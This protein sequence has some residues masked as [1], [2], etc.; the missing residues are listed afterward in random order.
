[1]GSEIQPVIVAACVVSAICAVISALACIWIWRNVREQIQDGDN[2]VKNHS[3]RS[4]AE[5]RGT[6]NRIEQHQVRRDDQI[7]DLADSIARIEAAGEVDDKHT[8]RPRDLGTIHDKINLIAQDVANL[9]G[10]QTAQHNALR[11][12][13]TLLQHSLVRASNFNPRSNRD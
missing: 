5:I 1:M 2:D 3:E 11:E 8:L 4:L 7:T 9:R 10:Q 13:L 6:V 12:Q